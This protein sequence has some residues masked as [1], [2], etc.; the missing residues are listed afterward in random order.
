[1]GDVLAHFVGGALLG[2]VLGALTGGV[3]LWLV[4]QPAHPANARGPVRIGR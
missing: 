4:A 1:V 3:L 2:A